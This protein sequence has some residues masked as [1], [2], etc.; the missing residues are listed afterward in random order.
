M[1]STAFTISTMETIKKMAADP[2]KSS[3]I[4]TDDT[5]LGGLVMVL[6]NK[7][8][9]IVKAA[10]ETLQ[11]LA[12][13]LENRDH[14]KNFLG[15]M[16]QLELLT[17]QASP[18]IKPLAERLYI[19]LRQC[20]LKAK[21]PSHPPPAEVLKECKNQQSEPVVKE[22]RSS[23]KVRRNSFFL[24]GVSKCKTITLFIRGM[25]HRDDVELCRNSLLTVSGVISITFDSK[26]RRAILRTKPSL[27]PE[28]LAQA[29][30]KTMT[31]YAEQ[32]VK[33]EDGNE[34]HISFGKQGRD[35]NK[36]NESMPDYPSD[37]DSPVK[38]HDNMAPMGGPQ[39]HSDKWGLFKS[40]GSFLSNSFYW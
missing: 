39:P 16:E 27:Q 15:M 29:I 14:M 20:P 34:V 24:G 4:V 21:K 13:H 37:N 9:S 30:A 5:C 8:A 40:M 36:E 18:V 11:L 26:A 23:R 3:A 1:D 25:D 6:S 31:M 12:E 17:Y 28:M 32:I 33:D 22:A 35:Y 10:L 38:G 7:D 19:S 2:F